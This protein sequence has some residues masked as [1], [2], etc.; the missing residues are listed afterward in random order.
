MQKLTQNASK[1]QNYKTL[2]KNLMMLDLAVILGY[3]TKGM[4]N[5]R[6]NNLNLIKIRKIVC[7]Y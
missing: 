4:G 3:G 7:Q 5:R 1:R 2:R 6:K